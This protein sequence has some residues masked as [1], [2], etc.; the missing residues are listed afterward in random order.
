MQWLDIY[1]TFKKKYDGLSSDDENGKMAY[2]LQKDT[3]SDM[4]IGDKIYVK[5]GD[6]IGT[7]GKIVD[8]E[9]NMQGIIFLPSNLDGYDEKLG[10]EKVECVRYFDQGD[11]VRVL[12]GKYKGESGIITSVDAEKVDMPTLKLDTLG[13]EITI[14][15]ANLRARDIREEDEKKHQRAMDTDKK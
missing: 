13:L 7:I 1:N 15:T 8:F 2:K 4:N 5:S 11:A 9:N 14:N 10:V 12:D 3:Q 6:L